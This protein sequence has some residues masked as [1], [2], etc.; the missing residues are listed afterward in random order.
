MVWDQIYGPLPKGLLPG[1]LESHNQVTP[2]IES[3]PVVAL[4]PQA[5]PTMAFLNHQ[6]QDGETFESI[7]A[8]YS[9]SVEELISVNGFTQAQPLGPGEVLLIPL[10]PRGN[11]EIDRVVA[12]GDLENEKVIL[13]HKG[14]GQIQMT[15]WSIQDETGNKFVFP[16]LTLF[17]AGIVNI[18][19][20]SGVNVVTDIFWGLN[21]AVWKSGATVTLVD[22]TG[23]TRDTYKIP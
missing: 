8:K 10:S 22:E 4:M 18:Y 20:R 14:K 9:V 5:T 23:V 6:V 21:K 12:A 19:T 13:K 11:V 3:T 16:Q 17:E 15:G 2:T 7:A 1:A